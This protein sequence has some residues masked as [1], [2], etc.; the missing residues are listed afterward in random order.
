MSTTAVGGKGGGGGYVGMQ[1]VTE[2]TRCVV[3]PNDT[4]A[5]QFFVLYM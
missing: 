2:M 3:I 4:I 1:G 5:H